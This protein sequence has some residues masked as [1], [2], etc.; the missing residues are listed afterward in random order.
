MEEG[1]REGRGKETFFA[2]KCMFAGE[3]IARNEIPSTR[4]SHFP[5]H[6]DCCCCS[7]SSLSLSLFR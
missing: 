4:K 5:M 7:N 3:R 6:F 2:E 1:R